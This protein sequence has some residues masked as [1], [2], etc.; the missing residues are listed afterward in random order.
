MQ[1]LSTQQ[2]AKILWDYHILHQEIGKADVIIAA[3][4]N[5]IRVAERGA[6][7]YLRKFAP[8]VVFSGGFGRLTRN[9]W[10]TPEA[11]VFADVA[12]KLGVPRDG[13]LIDNKSTN[14]SENL[15]FSMNSLSKNYRI[16]K[17]ALLV[18]KPFM[19]RRTLATWQKLFPDI[20]AFVTSPDLTYENYP[21]ESIT[22]EELINILVGDTQRIK[23]YVEKGFLVQQDIPSEVWNAYEELVRR[24]YS[25]HVV[26]E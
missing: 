9:N 21:T 15:R 20:L 10:T 25:Q 2:L 13:M 18:H 6:E 12:E 24:G 8:Y 23:I 16:P 11:E 1:D 26:N 22:R 3:G 7:L 14:T 5:D 19:E 17:K 4:S